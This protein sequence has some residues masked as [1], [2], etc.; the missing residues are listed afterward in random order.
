MPF[1]FLVSIKGK[2]GPILNM[3]DA[4]CQ[5]WFT[6]WGDFCNLFDCQMTLQILKFFYRNVYFQCVS[7][8]GGSVMVV[9]VG[10]C[11]SSH[12]RLSGPAHTMRHVTLSSQHTP[13]LRDR[14]DCQ[15]SHDRPPPSSNMFLIQLKTAFKLLL[16]RHTLYIVLFLVRLFLNATYYQIKGLTSYSILVNI[17][18]M[19]DWYNFLFMLIIAR[20]DI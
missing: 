10:T 2:N 6:N 1:L 20:P 8:H 19:Q 13:L 16:H 11:V 4:S 17:W 18:E 15:D 3:L 12:V 7:W 9:V 14:S 5:P